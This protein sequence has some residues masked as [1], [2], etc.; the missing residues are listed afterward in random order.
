MAKVLAMRTDRLGDI[1]LA[2]GYLSELAGIHQ[3]DLWVAPGL[4]PV[5]GILDPRINVRVTPFHSH[6]ADD[7]DIVARWLML[8]HDESYDVIVLSQ[9]THDYANLL[10]LGW[11]NTPQ[12]WG[13]ANA[14]HEGHFGWL[15][16]KF[17]NPVRDPSPASLTCAATVDPF[18]LDTEKY[19]ALAATCGFAESAQNGHPRLFR[20]G[21]SIAA[22]SSG[23]GTLIWPGSG[24]PQRRWPVDQFAD[25]LGRAPERYLDPIDV[26]GTTAEREIVEACCRAIRAVGRSSTSWIVEPD[27]LAQTA[28]ALQKYTRVLSNDTGI[29]HLAA[30]VGTPVD[31]IS[32]AQYQGRF[33]VDGDR[34]RT[35]FADIP[36]RRCRGACIFPD[37]E[38]WP[39]V[40]A[41][42]APAVADA[43]RAEAPGNTV[44]LSTGDRFPMSVLF[45]AQRSITRRNDEVWSELLSRIEV[46]R[47]KWET[48]HGEADLNQRI[49]VSRAQQAERQRD[50]L[51]GLLEEAQQQREQLASL[52]RQAEEQREEARTVLAESDRH[53]EELAT[54]LSDAQ[55]QRDE[56]RTHHDTLQEKLSRAKTEAGELRSK[57]EATTVL[58]EPWVRPGVG[59]FISIVTPSFGQAEFIGETIES[60]ASQGYEHF[61]HLVVDGGSTDGTVAAL[62]EYPNLQWVSEPDHGQAHAIN[63]GLLAARGDILAYINSDDFYLPGAF[64][65]VAKIFNDNPDVGMVVGGCDCVDQNSNKIGH[66]RARFD[67]VEDLIR[68]W[69]WDDWVCIPQPSTFWRRSVLEQVGLFDLDRHMALDYDMWL[70]IVQVTKVRTTDRTLAAFRLAPD[71]KTVS[72]THEMYLEEFEVSRNHWNLLPRPR[73]MRISIEARNHLAQRLLGVA[74]H[75]AL[76]TIGDPSLARRLAGDACRC[77][78]WILLNPRL[79]LTVLSSFAERQ[80]ESDHKAAHK[81]HRGYL[82]LLWRLS[83]NHQPTPPEDTE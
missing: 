69:G 80:G 3:V 56:W 28:G 35:F 46:E 27:Q 74:E 20:R 55:V 1:I 70:R 37:E 57:S 47:R 14:E 30:A 17:G 65:H 77:A 33:I 83:G 31:S 73:R 8:I 53:R 2:S 16:T 9:F 5:A 41:I 39:C 59:S 48:L 79:Y 43:L 34:S 32:P 22:R 10:A 21:Q 75:F 42:A 78:P 36:C 67:S 18:A 24:L 72:R 44:L 4:D 66:Y 82:T 19:A 40:S 51:R 76:N 64:E 25:L 61:E 81:L 6:L 38:T 45:A 68:Y 26:G 15:K 7:P 29:A 23:H 49:M 54:L 13:F 52:L 71:T 11:T 62:G 58:R 60:V 12:V 50:E 63:K